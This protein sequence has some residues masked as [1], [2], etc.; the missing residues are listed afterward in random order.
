MALSFAAKGARLFLW[1]LR[2]EL[3]VEVE[4]EIRTRY[5]S[6]EVRCYLCDVSKRAMVAQVA[7]SVKNDITTK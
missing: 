6:I 2:Q 3:L 7:T 5:P 1:D 4:K